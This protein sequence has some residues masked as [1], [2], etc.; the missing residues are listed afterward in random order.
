MIHIKS[1]QELDLIRQA[2]RIVA[3]TLD[4]LKYYIKPE[5]TT[6]EL[7]RRAAEFIKNLGGEPAF[8]GYK[9]FP[10]NICTS[11]NEEVVHGIPGQRKLQ[12]GDI[13]SIDV[14]VKFNGYYGDGTVTFGVG[15]ISQGAVRLLKIT[16][17]ALNLAIEQVVPRNRLSNIS[18]TIQKYIESNGFAVVREF[19][20]HG[21][22]ANMHEDPQIPNFGQPNRGVRLEPGMVLAIEPMVTEGSWEVSILDNGWT[23]VTKDRKLAAHF[24]HTV[25]VTNDGCEV[26]TLWQKN[27]Q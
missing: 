20:G 16:E 24:E 19:V 2:S 17:D 15:K 13:I 9:G 18:N 11:V 25:A 5:A 26:L 6:Q 23:A 1:A 3:E 7:D 12:E 21:I 22:G 14:G 4:N 10:A 8:L 27:N